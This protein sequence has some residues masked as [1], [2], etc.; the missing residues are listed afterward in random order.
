[1]PV[2]TLHHLPISAVSSAADLPGRLMKHNPAS[3]ASPVST[4]LGVP[5]EPPSWA[6]ALRV[7]F[8][9]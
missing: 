4:V 6:A 9:S 8:N 3:L 2:T 5:C 7:A 1:M